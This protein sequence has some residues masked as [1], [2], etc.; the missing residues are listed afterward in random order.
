M[1]IFREEEHAQ[2]V[3]LSLN[4][5]I[6]G[7]ESLGNKL[8]GDTL[9]ENAN[10]LLRLSYN[11]DFLLRYINEGLKNYEKFQTENNNN[12]QFLIFHSGKHFI[13]RVN[14]WLAENIF[15]HDDVV[16]EFFSYGLIH[17]HN[18][19]FLTVGYRGPGYHS[20]I[21][22]YRNFDSGEYCV[23]KHVNV[24]YL[25]RITLKPHMVMLY[26]NNVHIHSQLPPDE[27]SI[28]INLML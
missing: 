6:D 17:D 9:I 2:R 16:N 5:F 18:F 19:D 26:E 7:V 4:E 13:L 10:L 20:D 15:A 12:I 3:S 25:G 24:D 22:K 21:Y 28:S 14:F 11:Q 27:F 23:G 1:H 8:D